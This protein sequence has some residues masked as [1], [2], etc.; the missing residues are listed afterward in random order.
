MRRRKL[1]GKRKRSAETCYAITTLT[2]SQA[3]PAQLAAI[4]RSHWAIED[5]LH[6]VR[7][8]DFDEDRSQTRT[9]SGPRVMAS[10]RNLA[11]TILRLAGH[12]SIASALRHHARR[13]DRPLRTI[14]N[15]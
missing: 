2:A 6:W 5:R 9:A 14:M 10:L 15:C 8:M 3:S 12:A 4:I 13:P 1:A 7:D 11:I